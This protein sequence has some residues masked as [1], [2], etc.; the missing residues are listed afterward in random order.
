[1]A[2]S[3]TFRRTMRK[4]NSAMPHSCKAC[5]RD[6]RLTGTCGSTSAGAPG[7]RCRQPARNAAELVALA[8]DVI[9]AVAITSLVQMPQATRAVP[10]VFV[11][12]SDPVGA[13]F[14]ASLARR[15]ATSLASRSWNTASAKWLELRKE[16][17]PGVP[18]DSLAGS[19]QSFRDRSVRRH[20]GHGAVLAGGLE[21]GGYAR[22]RRDRAGDRGSRVWVDWRHD[23]ATWLADDHAP[24]ADHRAAAHHRDCLRS[25]AS[26][27][28]PPPAA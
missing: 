16:I 10:T 24:R 13:G 4:G 6:G 26:A 17:A 9:L 23:C 28:T 11:Q 21:P 15:A 25:I 5:R 18:G 12:V 27:T 19:Q 2:C 14:V 3:P 8:P 1:L 20:P 7:G 22:R